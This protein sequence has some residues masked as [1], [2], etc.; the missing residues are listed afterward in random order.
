MKEKCKR[1]FPMQWIKCIISWYKDI[2]QSPVHSFYATVQS[3]ERSVP[4]TATTTY[5]SPCTIFH[6]SQI[7][8][9]SL[10]IPITIRPLLLKIAY[11]HFPTLWKAVLPACLE[12]LDKTLI[13]TQFPFTSSLQWSNW[14]YMP[15][16][17]VHIICSSAWQGRSEVCCGRCTKKRWFPV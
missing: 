14:N 16:C 9:R 15:F 11:L 8:Q 2:M 6:C 7:Q 10:P 17:Y 12:Q 3:L 13:H 5:Q 4:T 1:Y